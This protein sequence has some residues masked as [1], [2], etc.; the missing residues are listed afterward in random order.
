MAPGPA[1]GDRLRRGLIFE[2]ASA[3]GVTVPTG[4]RKSAIRC[5]FHEDKTASAFP[6]ASNDS[7]DALRRRFERHEGA[8]GS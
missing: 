6:S 8:H 5:P 2:I 3:A 4:K 1:R 7:I